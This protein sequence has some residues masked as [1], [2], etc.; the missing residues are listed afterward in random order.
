MNL[1]FSK[2]LNKNAIYGKRFGL[3]SAG[4]DDS[5]GK[6]LRAKI[7]DIIERL[8]GELIVFDDNLLGFLL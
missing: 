2:N 5:E 3:L 1:M 6:K 8:G 4:Y 7:K